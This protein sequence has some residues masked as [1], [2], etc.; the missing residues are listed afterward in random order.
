VL[1]EGR[2][3]TNQASVVVSNIGAPSGST[4]KSTVHKNLGTGIPPWTLSFI[5]S[6]VR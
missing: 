6:V 2:E 1:S 3:P 5:E 4:R